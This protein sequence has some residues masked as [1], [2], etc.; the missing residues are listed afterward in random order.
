MRIAEKITSL[1]KRHEED[2]PQKTLH[3]LSKTDIFC[4]VAE[5]VQAL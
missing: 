1:F 5:L 3:Y 2:A 4:G